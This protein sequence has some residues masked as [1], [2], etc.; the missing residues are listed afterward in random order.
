MASTS[1]QSKHAGA[2]SLQGKLALVTGASRGLGRRVATTLGSAGAKVALV[3]RAEADLR[4]G[5]REIT[6]S[7]GTAR[8][9]PADVTTTESVE[10]LKRDVTDALGPVDV[11]INA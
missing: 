4:E 11:L 5:E 1:T 8:V 3:A 9:F 10:R 2:R 7:G 6:K